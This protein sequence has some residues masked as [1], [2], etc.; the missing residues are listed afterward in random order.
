MNKDDIAFVQS[1]DVSMYSQN[2]Q[3]SMIWSL[4]YDYVN[5]EHSELSSSAK[6]DLR[7]QMVA[8]KEGK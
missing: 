4:C 2:T 3:H 8:M 5:M 7:N 1:L 6:S